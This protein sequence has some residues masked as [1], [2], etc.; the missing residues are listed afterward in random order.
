MINPVDLLEV[1]MHG[2]LLG[3]LTMAPDLVAVFE[4]DASWI[5]EGFSISPFYLPLRAGIFVARRDPFGGLFGVFNDS[6]PDGWGNL[7][8]D[9]L[10]LKNGIQPGSISPIERL[11]IVGSSGMGALTYHPENKLIADQKHTHLNDLALEV[12]K[13]LHDESSDSL[14]ELFDKGG[15]SGGARPK[16]LVQV[17]G[18]E[19][20]IKFKSSE[21]PDDIGVT[22]YQ[23]SQL[24]I[25]CGIE[26]P[27]T[28]LFE[29]RY[30]GVKRF[31]RN[32]G[33][34]FHVHSASGLLYAS[35][36]FPSLDYVGLF[37]ATMV[38]TRNIEELKKFFRQMVFN[39][40]IGNKDDHS[41][42]FSFLY[43]E[44]RW[45]LSP[46]Y[47]LLRSNGFDNQHSTTI[48]G[49]GNPEIEDIFAVAKQA[50]LSKKTAQIIYEE[51]RD[52][53][54][55]NSKHSTINS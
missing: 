41:K 50:G 8:L 43:D 48:N 15:S 53:S 3:R 1:R 42:N 19:W 13:I 32:K 22:E 29:E 6:L 39:I 9:R 45:Y 44:G 55:P 28:R 34:R 2:D 35:H 36:R 37:N 12:E 27:E 21:D 54:F 4:Y 47:D 40:L 14:E 33:K 25:K 7:L 17:N 38:L 23:Y 52:N 30:F 31:D 24:A 5:A 10:L 16:V 51:V 46:A 18:E 11:S 20:L 26:M 49:K